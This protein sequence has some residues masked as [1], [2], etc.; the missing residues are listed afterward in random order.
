MLAD[1]TYWN[2][3]DIRI[4]KT[5]ATASMIPAA[6]ETIENFKKTFF[7]MTFK[8]AAPYFPIIDVKPN[9]R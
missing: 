5:M 1:T 8:E 6:Q 7:N 4:T 3:L 9:H 2:F